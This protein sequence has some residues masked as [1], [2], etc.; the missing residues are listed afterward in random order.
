MGSSLAYWLSENPDHDGTVLVVEPDPTYEKSSTT[1]S[2]ASIR[3]QF[4]EP[5]NIRLSM[6]ATE[7]FADFHQN[8]QVD[9]EA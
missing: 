1:L 4:S 8:V 2:E 5:V 7:F 3:H 6:F 9:D